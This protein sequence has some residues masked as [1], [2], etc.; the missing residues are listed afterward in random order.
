MTC[1]GCESGVEVEPGYTEVFVMRECGVGESCSS[2]FVM[3]K[4][5]VLFE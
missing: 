2:I 3:S 4:L 1:R 5:T